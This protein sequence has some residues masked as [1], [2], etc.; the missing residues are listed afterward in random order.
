MLPLKRDVLIVGAGHAGAHLA[1]SLRKKGF[2]GSILVVSDEMVLPYE[3]PPLSKAYFLG[4]IQIDRIF[5]HD[6]D[7]WR[8]HDIEFCLGEKVVGVD[9][10]AR[11]ATLS[12]GNQIDF[13]WCVLATGSRVRKLSC[14]GANLD[15]VYYL[16]TVS[17]ADKIR[18]NLNVERKIV[19]VGAGYVGLE[20]AAAARQLGH[21]VTVLETQDRV[22]SRMTCAE[23]SKVLE[24]SHL[25]HGVDIRLKESVEAIEG[26]T[27][28]RAVRLSSGDKLDADLIIVG[29]G[30]DGHT[31][32]AEAAGLNCDGGVVVDSFFRTS[33]PNILAIGD[34]SKHPNDYAGGPCRLESVQ[35]AV[36]SAETAAETILN[37]LRPYDDLPTFWSDQYDLKLQTA[38]ITKGADDIVF[39]GDP[40]NGPLSALYLKKGQ[41][42]AID[43]INNPKDF[44]AARKL[45]RSGARP[46]R[47]R[48]ANGD[49]PLKSFV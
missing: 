9:V 39:R 45:I 29:I 3:R 35:H 20:V 19:V 15:G 18:R 32:L 49:V 28:A 24:R 13:N 37:A 10:E 27:R 36:S 21:Q 34:C 14:C 11:L 12:N 47:E 7:Y 8:E 23:I 44:M 25:A 46:D 16:R 42:V 30:I 38:G 6:G 22:L 17:D 5:I 48:L 4:S 40:Q 31:E 1:T 2:S 43:A 26:D 33:A 41:L